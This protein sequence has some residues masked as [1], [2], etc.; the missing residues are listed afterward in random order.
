MKWVCLLRMESW[1]RGEF[2]SVCLTTPAVPNEFQTDYTHSYFG[3]GLRQIRLE[4]LV[5]RATGLR[6][7]LWRRRSGLGD[8]TSNHYHK[9]LKI[10]PWLHLMKCF[11]HVWCKYAQNWDIFLMIA[12]ILP[13]LWDFKILI[14]SVPG[15]FMKIK[16]PLINT[17]MLRRNA[18]LH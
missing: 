2:V 15:N 17:I 11:Y 12:N 7:Q 14:L 4:E 5:L 9:L 1:P 8:M 10:W 3:N 13:F 18:W 16:E 6:L